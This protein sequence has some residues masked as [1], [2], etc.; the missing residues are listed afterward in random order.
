MICDVL[1]VTPKERNTFFNDGIMHIARFSLIVERQPLNR[2]IKL[3][4]V[5]F[6]VF[7]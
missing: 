4:K 7:I 3:M 2:C 6:I 1:N 5:I